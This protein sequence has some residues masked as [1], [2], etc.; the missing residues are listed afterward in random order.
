[1]LDQASWLHT[2]CCSKRTVHSLRASFYRNIIWHSPAQSFQRGLCENRRRKKDRDGNMFEH[3]RKTKQNKRLSPKDSFSWTQSQSPNLQQHWLAK[4]LQ[5]VQHNICVCG[6]FFHEEW[7]RQQREIRSTLT[8]GWLLQPQGRKEMRGRIGCTDACLIP[9]WLDRVG[10]FLCPLCG[11]WSER[12]CVKLGRAC[13]SAHTDKCVCGEFV[14][15]V[16]AN[17]HLP[18]VKQ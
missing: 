7:K 9:D 3:L 1:M 11:L 4:P 5:A 18:S 15:F 2:L 16:H 8:C 14:F 13:V 6:A 17:L 12:H 10:L